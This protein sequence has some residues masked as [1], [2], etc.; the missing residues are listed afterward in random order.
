[1]LSPKRGTI[2][3]RRGRKTPEERAQR[4]SHHPQ[5]GGGG[6]TGEGGDTGNVLDE[7]I[8]GPDG[9]I[10]TVKGPWHCGQFV[11]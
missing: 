5:K 4:V 1:V 6:G 3:A 8:G 7:F 9:A 10:G 2:A 11:V